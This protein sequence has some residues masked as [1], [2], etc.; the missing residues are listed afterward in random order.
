MIN[1]RHHPTQLRTGHH[2]S[3]SAGP[4]LGGYD[5]G[6]TYDRRLRLVLVLVE[7]N[8]RRQLVIRD[9]ATAVNLSSGRLA[10]LFKSEVGISP[11]RYLNNLR[12]EKAKELLENG[13]LSCKEIAAE[14]GIPNASRFCRSFKAQYG[15]TP[16]EYRSTHLRIKCL[17]CFRP[18]QSRSANV[19]GCEEQIQSSQDNH[20]PGH[21]KISA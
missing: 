19:C 3:V 10:H 2:E 4:M 13:L 12:M 5:G 6:N 20:N 16:K 14:V 17:R 9:L 21:S 15:A 11:Q 8:M 7:D 1:L 18:D